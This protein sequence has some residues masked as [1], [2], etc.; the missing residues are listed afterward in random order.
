MNIKKYFTN[1]TL[2]LES[3]KDRVRDYIDDA[4]W[5]SDGEW[6]ES[7]IRTIL[8]RHLPSNIGVGRGFVVNVDQ[9]STQIDVLL[10]DKSKPVLFQDGDFLVITRDA[11]R[12]AIEVKTKIRTRKDLEDAINKLSDI[13]LLIDPEPGSN[14]YKERFFGLFSYEPLGFNTSEVL[15]SVQQCVGGQY[16]RIV[17]C[18]SLGKDYFIRFWPSD[19]KSSA[20]F[21]NYDKWHSYN[22]QNKAPAYFVHNVIDHLCPQWANENID[23]WYPEEGK[24]DHKLSEIHLSSSC[25]E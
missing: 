19:P 3:L 16:Q 11:A 4:H 1:L 22:L 12:G 13:A 6:K 2:E 24:E 14:Y 15:N 5:L 25:T 18:I 8:R 10:Y 21:H 17:N 7:V 20:G 23:I 9:C